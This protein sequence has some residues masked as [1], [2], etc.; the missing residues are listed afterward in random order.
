MLT[1]RQLHPE[2]QADPQR[3]QPSNYSRTLAARKR[4]LS[5]A[6]LKPEF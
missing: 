6:C 5:S 3:A 2:L 4:R 1:L